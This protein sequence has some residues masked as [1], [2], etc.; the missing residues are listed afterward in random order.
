VKSPEGIKPLLEE[1]RE[2]FPRLSHLW[3]DAGYR[4][5]E[6]SRGWVEK[7]SGWTVDLLVE[8]PRKSALEEVLKL[9]AAEWAKEAEKVD[10]Q[11]LMPPRGFQGRLAR[12]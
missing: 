4:G 7:V 5:K 2:L 10:W 9:W 3:L 1:I 6:K 12:T 8:R 11:K